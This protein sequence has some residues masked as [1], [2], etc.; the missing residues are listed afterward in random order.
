[1]SQLDEALIM[2]ANAAKAVILSGM[3]LTVGALIAWIIW[4]L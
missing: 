1:M 4:H 3:M 2:T